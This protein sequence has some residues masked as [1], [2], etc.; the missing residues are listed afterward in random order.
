MP[1]TRFRIVL[2]EPFD[3]IGVEKL[4]TVG[5]IA[6][7]LLNPPPTARMFWRDGDLRAV[8]SFKMV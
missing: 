6:Y 1:E 8:L 4:R 2:A 3:R 7:R 5:D